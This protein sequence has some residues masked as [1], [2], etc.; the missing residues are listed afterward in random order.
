MK[1]TTIRF[2]LNWRYQGPNAPFVVAQERGLFSA[3]GLDVHLTPGTGS[4]AVPAQL[5]SG[6][7]DAGFGDVTALAEY[8]GRGGKPDAITVAILYSRS[9]LSVIVA[10]DSTIHVPAD[11]AGRRLCGPAIDTAFRMFPAFARVTGLDVGA[12]SL[13]AVAPA[14]RDRRLIE[15]RTDGATGF[16]ST[17]LFAL[18]AAGADPSAYRLMAYADHGVDVYTS[19]LQVSRRLAETNPAAVAALVRAVLRA[20][21]H[22]AADPLAAAQALCRVDPSVDVD[23]ARD[24]LT[25]AIARQLRTAEVARIGLGAATAERLAMTATMAAAA[26]DLPAPPSHDALFDPRFLPPF[27]ERRLPDA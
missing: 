4:S 15:R 3:A 6:A 2:L 8:L 16:D 1:P 21:Q 20:W 10:H 19:A 5:A 25:F 11:L 14:E 12:V 13:D 17:L 27:E 22:A 23:L 18:R 26:F 24:H 9:P 7:F